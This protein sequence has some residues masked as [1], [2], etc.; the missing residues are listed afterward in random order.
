MCAC[1]YIRMSVYVYVCACVYECMYSCIYAYIY[2]SLYI[3][4]IPIVGFHVWCHFF[5]DTTIYTTI[6]HIDEDILAVVKG[7]TT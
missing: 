6:Y 1:I 5:N 4:Y 7:I 2:V 3:I